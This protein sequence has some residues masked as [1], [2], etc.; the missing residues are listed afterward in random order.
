MVV[1]ENAN[2]VGE[3]VLQ[4]AVSQAKKEFG[5]RLFAC[6]ALGSLA[7][8]GFSPLVSDVDFGIILTS[9]LTS[10]DD[11]QIE[12][13][14]NHVKN[15]PIAL[16]ERLSI[17]WGS[18]ASLKN[19]ES[20]GRFPPIDKLDLIQHGKLLAGNDVRKRT[21][22]PEPTQ[23]ELEVSGADLAVNLLGT[24]EMI[25][26]FSQPAKILDQGVRH[27]TKVVLF[28]VRF[29]Y[30]AST[31]NMGRNDVAVVY[32]LDNNKGDKA[33]LAK[34]AF[35]WRDEPPKDRDDTIKLLER[36]LI[37]LYLQFI[38]RYYPQMLYYQEVNLAANLKQWREQ[39]AGIMF[40]N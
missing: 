15:L 25:E 11:S 13:I 10:G 17:F 1:K 19:E 38:D 37:P 22:L 27:L 9:P 4:E 7:H 18:I 30:T 28:P 34:Q 23:R 20:G 26:E 24:P 32:Y 3:I 36:A 2:Q 6:Y 16:G 14:K 21:R 40:L 31:G 8:G 12:S 35:R 33:E 29:L 5:S 39:L